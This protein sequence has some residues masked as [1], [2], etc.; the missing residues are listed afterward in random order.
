L[1]NSETIRTPERQIGEPV[2]G[3]KISQ[4]DG[5]LPDMENNKRDNKNKHLL[6]FGQKL[7]VISA[8]VQPDNSCGSEKVGLV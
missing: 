7:A 8:T 3:Y 1:S 6:N 4:T 2:S 5:N